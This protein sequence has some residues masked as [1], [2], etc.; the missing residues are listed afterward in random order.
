MTKKINFFSVLMMFFM[1]NIV[2]FAQTEQEYFNTG[3]QHFKAQKYDDAIESYQKALKINPKFAKAAHNLGNIYYLL[4]ESEEAMKYYNIAIKNE[5]NDA[6]P[7]I[8]RGFLYLD[9][10]KIN[11]A[12]QDAQKSLKLKPDA[13]DTH[14]LLGSIREI[15]NKKEDACKFWKMAAG[16]GHALASEAVK[17]KC[18]SS[19]KIVEKEEK[20]KLKNPN[21][22]KDFIKNGEQKLEK[23]DYQNALLDF[24]KAI[25]LDTKNGQ[26]YFGIGNAKFA[27]G[28]QDEACK[29]WRKALELGYK[30]SKEMLQGVCHE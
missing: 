15:Q 26:A 20:K 30:K 11:Q 13:P 7:Y 22:A 9:L 5:P 27:Q 14:F 4:A 1:T 24:E 21:S 18:N 23:R 28:E 12:E 17:N 2:L 25:Q 8:S 29:A 19:T 16:K 6:A 3:N 10:R